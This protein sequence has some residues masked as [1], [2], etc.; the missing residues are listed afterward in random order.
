MK[1]RLCLNK[2][3]ILKKN[4]FFNHIFKKGYHYKGRYL[5]IITY[6]DTKRLIGFTVDKKQRNA[7]IRNRIR[8]MLREIYRTNKDKFPEEIIIIHA[9]HFES[10]VRYIDLKNDILLL[11]NKIYESSEVYSGNTN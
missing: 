3:E 11:L 1:K 4:N 5:N 6:S 9:K 10:F 7:V 8:R 2:N